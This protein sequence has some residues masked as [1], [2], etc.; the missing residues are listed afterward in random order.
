[1]RYNW[2]RDLRSYFKTAVIGF[3]LPVIAVILIV[4][5]LSMH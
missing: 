4:W 3:G 2:K 1:M 5:L